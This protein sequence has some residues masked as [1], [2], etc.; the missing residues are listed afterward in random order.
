[1]LEYK[2][3][4]AGELRSGNIEHK[5]LA[6]EKTLSGVFSE[7]VDYVIEEIKRILDP[8]KSYVREYFSNENIR[9]NYFLQRLILFL[10]IVICFLTIFQYGDKIWKFVKAIICAVFKKG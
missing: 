1:I 3:A 10:T 4:P 9:A 6:N 7:N 2:K 5:D 8:V